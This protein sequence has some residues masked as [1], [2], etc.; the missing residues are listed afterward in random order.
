MKREE[1][2]ERVAEAAHEMN[3]IYCEATGDTSQPTW[4]NA[5]AWQRESA[6][7]GV[8]LALSGA[9]PEQQHEAWCQDKKSRGWKW[10]L[11]KNAEDKTHPCLVPYSELPEAQRRKDGLYIATVR[12]MHTA[13]SA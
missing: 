6:V 3:R 9:T 8:E 1:I 10:G 2:I 5:P 7:Q 12:A 13:L 11:D 4:A